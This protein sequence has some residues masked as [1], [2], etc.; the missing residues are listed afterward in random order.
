VGALMCEQQRWGEAITLF[1]EGIARCPGVALLH[2]NRGIA[3]EESYRADEALRSYLKCLW[4]EPS[5][6]DAH[7]NAARLLELKGQQQGAL[8]HYSA[9]RRLQRGK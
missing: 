2:F 1:D 6:A 5:F 7:Y 8:Q 9:Y 3:L 4:L